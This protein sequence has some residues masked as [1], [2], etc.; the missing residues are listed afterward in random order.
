MNDSGLSGYS[1]S[2]N[3]GCMKADRASVGPLNGCNPNVADFLMEMIRILLRPLHSWV[4][5]D[6]ARRAR[7][8]LRFAET[9]A[10]GGRDL[11]RA[12]KALYGP[13]AR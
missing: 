6:T 4:W 1:H 2:V 7:K 9:E 8:L 5:L 3:A 10:E 13:R 12:A 11:A